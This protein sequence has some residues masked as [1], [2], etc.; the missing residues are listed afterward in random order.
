MLDRIGYYCWAGPGT[1]RMI[2]VKYFDPQIDAASLMTSYD[3]DYLARLKDLFG[4][5]DFWGT[6]SWG[7]SD[8]TEVEDR[9][10]LIDRVENFKRLNIR[11][12]AYIQG[13]NLVY[14]EFPDK[15]WWARDERGRLIPYYK[16][17]RMCSIHS[18]EYL[19]YVVRK[20]QDTHNLGFDGIYVDNIQHGQLGVPNKPGEL[21]FV[22]CG[23]ASEFARE[24]FRQSTG[25]SLP[26]DL[27]KDPGLT[28]AY[29]DFRVDENVR[30][31]GLLADAAHAGGMAFGTN[32]YD[33]KFDPTYIYAIDLER[34]AALQDYLLFENH[35]L[36]SSDGKIN[37]LYIEELIEQHNIQKP[38]FVVSYRNGVGMA[39]QSTQEE[40]DNVFSEGA[41][42]RFRL[43]LKG[44]EF[45][46]RNVWHNLH[47]DD[48]ESPQQDKVL[49]RVHDPSN[50]WALFL[51]L[52]FPPF[53]WLLKRY[54]NPIY[55]IAFEE[56]FFFFLVKI[57]YDT[58]LK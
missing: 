55:R 41:V 1:I 40:L 7:F 44:S 23:D 29:L 17:R 42:A 19:D 26:N 38:V 32:F 49:P 9:R 37:N 2:K 15:N 56:R 22:F 14:D 51:A 57:V 24:R 10:F 54:Y 5:T 33:P 12:H 11:L 36:P 20:I 3:Y 6:Y 30:Y 43:C 28:R 39:P 34:M 46:T 16:G 35:S 8:Q 27:E 31:V 53:R 25:L 18:D 47:L 21:P 48:Y 50:L 58:T 52:K 4:I 13:P 45:T